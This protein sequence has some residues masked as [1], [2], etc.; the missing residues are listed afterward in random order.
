MASARRSSRKTLR[1][2]SVGVSTEDRGKVSG[3]SN[4]GGRL[5][6]LSC[7]AC[8]PKLTE[9][10]AA[11][12]IETTA[13]NAEI[14]RGKR[15]TWPSPRRTVAWRLGLFNASEHSREIGSPVSRGYD[16]YGK[17][18]GN[19]V[20]RVAAWPTRLSNTWSPSSAAF[21]SDRRLPLCGR[22]IRK[23][24]PYEGWT[25]PWIPG[26]ESERHQARPAR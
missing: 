24:G 16:W 13:V 22:S 4:A 2:F 21:E 19:P 5:G 23:P 17:Y 9:T 14:G 25:V 26:V 7:F 18:V 1:G 11:S 20:D 6:G 8:S 15:I 10:W 12:T 3:S